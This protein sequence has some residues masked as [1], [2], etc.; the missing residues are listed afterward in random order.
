MGTTNLFNSNANNLSFS[1]VL[2]PSTVIWGDPG[3]LPKGATRFYRPGTAAVSSTEIFIRLSQKC[4][5]KSL[6][7]RSLT[8]PGAGNTD[9]WTVRRNGVDTLLAVSL[10]GTQTANINN[11]ASVS[12]QA[13]DSLSLKVTTSAATTVTDTVIQVDVF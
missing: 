2:Q 9:I 10:T 11:A 4:L 7:I 5:L 6:S 3:S 12:F 1:A 8:G 13:G